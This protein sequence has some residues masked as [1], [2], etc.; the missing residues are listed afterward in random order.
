MR[1]VIFVT[2]SRSEY[3]LIKPAFKCKKT[4]EIDQNCSMRKSQSKIFGN[5][6]KDIRKIIF[7]K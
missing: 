5:T 1:K 3:Y 7:K 2:S 4:K 6:Y